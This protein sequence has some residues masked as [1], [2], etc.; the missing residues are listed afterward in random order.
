R[1]AASSSTIKMRGTSPPLLRGR[2]VDLY[3]ITQI[4]SFSKPPQAD[5][6]PRGAGWGRWSGLRR[7]HARLH[8][9]RQVRRDPQHPFHQHELRAM[10]HLVFLHAEE[11][12]KA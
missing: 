10:M 4:L 6:L 7:G 5:S 9:P 11:K 3:Y 12:F 2:T 8:L 1:I